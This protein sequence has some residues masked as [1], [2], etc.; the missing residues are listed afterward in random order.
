MAT[1]P[2]IA[3]VKTIY[4]NSDGSEKVS[5]TPSTETG[6][7]DM[8]SVTKKVNEFLDFVNLVKD[9]SELSVDNPTKTYGLQNGSWV[10]VSVTPPVDPDY[11]VRVADNTSNYRVEFTDTVGDSF[12][13]KLMSFSFNINPVDLA[14]TGYLLTVGED[15]ATNGQFYMRIDATTGVIR[16]KRQDA[17]AANPTAVL[18]SDAIIAGQD[19]TIS[20]ANGVLLING[21]DQSIDMSSFGTVTTVTRGL[22]LFSETITGV[23]NYRGDI[24]AVN[25]EGTDAEISDTD[26][27]FTAINTT[28]SGTRTYIEY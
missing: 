4:D 6:A 12:D 27:T 23:N 26:L 7:Y 21:V 9:G 5:V 20:L 24:K 11:L 8:E 2:I 25:Y 16:L 19:N 17:N 13:P 22:R 10:E 14:A 15:D 3:L 18:S 28:E 1:P